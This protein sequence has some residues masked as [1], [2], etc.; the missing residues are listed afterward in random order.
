MNNHDELD[1]TNW[2]DG[3]DVVAKLNESFF[4]YNQ[5]YEI[6][7]CFTCSSGCSSSSSGARGGRR[8]CFCCC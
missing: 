3:G 4:Y 1:E 8:C 2:W 6:V 5:T 7:R